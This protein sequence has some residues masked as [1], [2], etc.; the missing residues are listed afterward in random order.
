M[1]PYKQATIKTLMVFIA[2]FI[3]LNAILAVSDLR[4]ALFKSFLFDVN[5][6]YHKMI[7]PVSTALIILLALISAL[8]GWRVAALKNRDRKKWASLCL[9]FNLWSVIFLCFLPRVGVHGE[10]QNTKSRGGQ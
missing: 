10:T 6:P 1:S 5:H 7:P 8:L 9:L 4:V 2:A 3:V